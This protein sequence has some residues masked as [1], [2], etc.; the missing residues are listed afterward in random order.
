MTVLELNGDFRTRSARGRSRLI[1]LALMVCVFTA[2]CG[3]SAKA[4][5]C[6]L[7]YMNQ[8]AS[9]GGVAGCEVVTQV[10]YGPQVNKYLPTGKV[11]CPLSCPIEYIA[12]FVN[13]GPFHDVAN[14]WKGLDRLSDRKDVLLAAC[15]GSLRPISDVKQFYTEALNNTMALPGRKLLP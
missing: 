11:Y 6:G 1:Y 14:A 5:S 10:Y 13:T 15:D 8:V 7:Y 3:A 4:Q 12:T 9:C 2:L